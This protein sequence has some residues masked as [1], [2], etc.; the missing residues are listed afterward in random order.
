VCQWE[1][2]GWGNFELYL[3]DEH[4]PVSGMSDTSGFYFIRS[5]NLY[6]IGCTDDLES[7]QHHHLRRLDLG[8]HPC[9][10][11]QTS[12]RDDPAVFVAKGW[13]RENL[14][15]RAEAFIVNCR[16]APAFNVIVLNDQPV[17][18]DVFARLVSP[19]GRAKLS[20]AQKNRVV[21]PETRQR[22][23]QGKKGGA[24]PRSRPVEVVQGDTVTRFECA[25]Y[26][27]AHLGV[28]KQCIGLALKKGHRCGGCVVRWV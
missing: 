21:S 26:A 6:L 27:A 22:M 12:H 7:S 8:V 23:S 10:R 18:M 14:V 4:V 25:A 19:E 24:H 11:L 2:V 15:E 20:A 5:G 28:S 9:A 16:R 13:G 17:T 3:K 1:K